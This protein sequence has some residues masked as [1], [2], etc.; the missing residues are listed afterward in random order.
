ML[1]KTLFQSLWKLNL[2]WDYEVPSEMQVSSTRWLGDFK[3]WISGKFLVSNVTHAGET[4]ANL[5]YTSSKMPLK[6]VMGNVCFFELSWRMALKIQ[7]WCYPR[8][9]WHL[10]R[11]SHCPVWSYSGLCYVIDWWIVFKELWIWL[12]ILKFSVDQ[13]L[14]W[15]CAGCTVNPKVENFHWEPSCPDSGIGGFHLLAP[16]SQ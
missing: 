13:I 8:P 15:F 10:S 16:L 2:G 1:V 3:F 7:P 14:R 12:I 11:W 5:R 6:R 9:E 4:S